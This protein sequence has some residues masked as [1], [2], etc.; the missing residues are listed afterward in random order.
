[1]SDGGGIESAT[2][3]SARA[4]EQGGQFIVDGD[5]QVDDGPVK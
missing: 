3:V 2:E 5:G 1:M 4:V